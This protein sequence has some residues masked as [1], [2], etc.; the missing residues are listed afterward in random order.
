[1]VSIGY[2]KKLRLREIGKLLQITQAIV[3]ESGFQ[4]S[5]Q[6]PAVD[7]LIC[8]LLWLRLLSLPLTV[9]A[10]P[11]PGACK[12]PLAQHE[13][14]TIILHPTVLS[15]NSCLSCPA[16]KVSLRPDLTRF[17]FLRNIQYT[18]FSPQGL[19]YST[20]SH[21]LTLTSWC[22]SFTKGQLYR[23][24]QARIDNLTQIK[25]HEIDKISLQDFLHIGLTLILFTTMKAMWPQG[26]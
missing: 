8:V 6:I 24:Q 3:E 22:V 23:C 13:G 11:F 19:I 25:S 5:C 14:K 1:M 9:L 15:A 20:V 2:G 7:H 26:H 16:C 18:T 10:L 12:P 21:I 4:P 17:F